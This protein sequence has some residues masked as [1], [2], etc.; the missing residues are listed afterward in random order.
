MWLAIAALV[1]VLWV[2]GALVFEVISGLI[3]LLIILA[4]AAVVIHFV[5][6]K[7]HS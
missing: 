1:F 2:L 4:A 7:K 5:R 6:R 3:H